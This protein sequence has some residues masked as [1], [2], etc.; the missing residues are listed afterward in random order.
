MVTVRK[1]EVLAPVPPPANP[2]CLCGFLC[3]PPANPHP[4]HTIQ[5][6]NALEQAWVCLCSPSMG[7]P[8]RSFKA[9]HKDCPELNQ[10]PGL[11]LEGHFRVD[12]ADVA[13]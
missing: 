2:L 9:K 6:R 13:W 12:P 3:S 8:A 11:R 10:T 7:G 1:V 5:I 4:S